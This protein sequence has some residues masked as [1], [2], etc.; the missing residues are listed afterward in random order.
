MREALAAGHSSELLRAAHQMK[1]AG[2]S[3]GFPAL[4]RLG[5][6][7]ELAARAADAQAA[8]GVLGRLEDL[9]SQIAREHRPHA[10]SQPKAG[11]LVTR[12]T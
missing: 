7:L 10:D 2:G 12:G 4:S 11:P 6:E 8:A 3:F 9:C 5:G 1:G